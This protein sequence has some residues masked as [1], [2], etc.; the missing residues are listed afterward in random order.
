MPADGARH[1]GHAAGHGFERHHAERLV[2]GE[3][4]DEARR[5]QQRRHLG[6]AEPAEELHPAGDA[7]LPRHPAQ[8]AHLGVGVQV[9]APRAAGDGEHGAG[10]V[11]ECADRGV[12]ALALHEPG[13]HRD[14]VRPA[15]RPRARRR[16]AAARGEQAQVD[17]ARHHPDAVARDAH[18]RQFG[19]LVGAGRDDGVGAA[20]DRALQPDPRGGARVPAALVAALDGAER[21]VG[22]HDRHAP[23]PRRLRGLDRREAAHPEV[24]VRDVGRVAGPAPLQ[25]GAEVVHPGQQVVLGDALG[26]PRRDVL[27]GHAGGEPYPVRQGGRVPAGVDGDVVALAAEF[28]GQF[29]DE[30][31]LPAAVR[32]A[33]PAVGGERAGVLGDHG[34]SHRVTSWRVRRQSRRKRGRP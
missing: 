26:R 32:P 19:D 3:R 24:G 22:L 5:A 34:Y 17:P 11:R 4:D 1:H 33:Q 29:R 9:A 13:Q 16:G 31:V 6:A 20:A 14:A 18:R 12:D 25:V 30:H 15:V 10:Q 7:G 21:V 28:G 2:P 8:P 23:R 27:D